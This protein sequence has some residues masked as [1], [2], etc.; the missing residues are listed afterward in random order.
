VGGLA[1]G[2]LEAPP[3]RAQKGPPAHAAAP[4]RP[5]PGAGAA[6]RGGP[7]ATLRLID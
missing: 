1:P 7:P 6:P 2:L 4:V 3:P 5:A